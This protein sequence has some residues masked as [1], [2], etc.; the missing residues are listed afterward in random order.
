VKEKGT[1]LFRAGQSCRGVFVIRSGQVQLSLGAPGKLY[2]P[3]TVGP[4]FVV[5]LPAT[6][7]G[8]PYSLTAEAKSTCRLDFIARAKLLGLLRQNPEAGFQVLRLLSEEIF[9]MRKAVKKSDR[10]SRY[11]P[12]VA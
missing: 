5:G 1:I 12:K 10:N 11:S 4:G 2:P 6:F 8:E 3:H 9:A 7:S